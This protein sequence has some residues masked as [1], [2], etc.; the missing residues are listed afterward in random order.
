MFGINFS[1]IIILFPILHFAN[2]AAA[3]PDMPRVVTPFPAPKLTDLPQ[4][5]FQLYSLHH[6]YSFFCYFFDE[7]DEFGLLYD[8]ERTGSVLSQFQGQHKESLYWGTY[9][10]HLYLGIRAR[11]NL[12]VS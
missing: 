2:Y 1:I 9:R 11:F 8:Y 4:V 3:E 10:P 6:C 5:D 12:T 7:L